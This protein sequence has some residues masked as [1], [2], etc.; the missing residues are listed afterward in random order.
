MRA[1]KRRGKDQLWKKRKRAA[2]P[3][4]G[5]AGRA[6]MAIVVRE[7][8]RVNARAGKRRI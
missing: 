6:A 8:M 3:G 4:Q 2:R 1:V 5:E 7:A